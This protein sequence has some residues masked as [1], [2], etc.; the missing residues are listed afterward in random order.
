MMFFWPQR[1][2]KNPL[3][4]RRKRSSF[5]LDYRLRISA[6]QETDRN[7][8]ACNKFFHQMAIMPLRCKVGLRGFVP[9][10]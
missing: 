1:V 8:K 4:I 5:V 9:S 10:F 3:L 6:S 7:D 2:R